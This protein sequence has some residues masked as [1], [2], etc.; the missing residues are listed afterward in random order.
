[1]PSS[2]VQIFCYICSDWTG[3]KIMKTTFVDYSIHY[4]EACTRCDFGAKYQPFSPWDRQNIDTTKESLALISDDWQDDEL[5]DIPPTLE[6][7]VKL[8]LSWI[9]PEY[10]L[11]QSFSTLYVTSTLEAAQRREKPLEPEFCMICLEIP[12]IEKELECSHIVCTDCYRRINKEKCPEC[13]C[14][15]QWDGDIE[16]ILD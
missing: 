14:L 16:K 5:K 11:C 15:L 2:L 8:Y 10:Q 6:N 3:L 7:A 12:L 13:R 1:M 4:I 9:K